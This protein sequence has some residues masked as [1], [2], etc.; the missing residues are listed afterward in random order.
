M[1]YYNKLTDQ[2]TYQSVE[3]MFLTLDKSD[4]WLI[5]I[6]MRKYV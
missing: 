6:H 3:E 1:A 2:D 4:N 5:C